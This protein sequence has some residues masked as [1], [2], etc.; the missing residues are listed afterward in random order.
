[1]QMAVHTTPANRFFVTAIQNN[2]NI[3]YDRSEVFIK[4]HKRNIEKLE[5]SYFA[6]NKFLFGI[7]ALKIYRKDFRFGPFRRM[8]TVFRNWEACRD[9][10]DF[11]GLFG[12]IALERANVSQYLLENQDLSPQ[13]CKYDGYLLENESKCWEKI[14]NYYTQFQNIANEKGKLATLLFTYSITRKIKIELF[15]IQLIQSKIIRGVN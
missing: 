7:N 9:G 6:G 14:A 13:T 8:T 12:L 10:G 15:K 4:A 5:G 1:L 11:K 2:S 3:C